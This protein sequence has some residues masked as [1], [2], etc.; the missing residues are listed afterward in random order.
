MPFA[1]PELRAR[2]KAA[3]VKASP[4]AERVNCSRSHL[5]N[6][7]AGRKPGSDELFARVAREL[8]CDVDDLVGPKPG[9]RPTAAA[10]RPDITVNAA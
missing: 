3:G 2:R 7:E 1:T 6:V 9:T 8:A 10:H 5:L 4:F